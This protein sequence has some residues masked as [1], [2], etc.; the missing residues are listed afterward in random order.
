MMKYI[1]SLLFVILGFFFLRVEVY[2]VELESYKYIYFVEVEP[3]LKK[4]TF[5]INSE[6]FFHPLT[7]SMQIE[8]A[9]MQF[10]LQQDAFASNSWDVGYTLTAV[11]PNSLISN[12]RGDISVSSTNLLFPTQ[13]GRINA[14]EQFVPISHTTRWPGRVIIPRSTAS[15]RV[16]TH[17]A[18]VH[19]MRS[20][21]ST[22]STDVVGTVDLNWI[23]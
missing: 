3:G 14:N 9:R 4:A 19:F 12:F 22:F 8:T 13:F 5:Y 6:P 10:L 18:A 20:G 23:W 17:N 1:A 7:R 21:W 15:V 2:G 11:T 16:R